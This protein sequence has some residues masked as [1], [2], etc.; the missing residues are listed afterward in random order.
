[1][2]NPN[3]NGYRFVKDGM[4]LEVSDF[5]GNGEG[6]A[7]W[8]TGV[9]YIA[10]KAP[11]LKE[12]ILSCYRKFTMINK[13]KYWYQAARCNDGYREDDVSR[14]QTIMSIASLKVNGDEEE[15][16]EIAL[17]LPYRLS[18][19]FKMGPTM[20]F[21]LRAISGK[22]KFYTYM[23]QLLELIE[24]LPSVLWNKILRKIM[25]WNKEYSQEWYCDYDQSIPF[26]HFNEE[27][28]EYEF[29]NEGFHWVNN[30]H[31]L[32]SYH[33]KKK[34]TNKFYKFM[35]TIEY[36]EY[37]LHLTSWMIYTSE[38][39]FLKKILQKLAIWLAEK[40]NLLVRLLMKDKVTQEEI[41]NYKP[42]KGFRW[43]SRFDG[44][45]YRYYLKDDD[46]I[47]NA[48]DKDII[49]TLFNN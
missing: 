17:H 20:W 11:Q 18:R 45:S 46:I 19:R 42:T 39:T 27:T 2:F 47:N 3:S 22:G 7:L 16:K 25:G 9:A 35:N 38:D 34:N 44:R 1:M 43:S 15:L 4:M 21:W 13:K 49:V 26:W 40:D 24:F 5:E 6:D 23:F 31:K 12:G 48:I 37:A 14:D 10:Y 8:R 33:H 41:D 28:Q 30:G 36:P 29:I 32:S